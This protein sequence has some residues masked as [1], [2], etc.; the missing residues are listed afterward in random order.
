MSHF[1]LPRDLEADSFALFKL[2]DL[3]GRNTLCF[4]V[5]LIKGILSLVIRSIV[6]CLALVE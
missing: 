3:S 2:D 4:R 5:R 6:L 1:T